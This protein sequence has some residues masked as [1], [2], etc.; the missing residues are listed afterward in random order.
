MISGDTTFAN[1]GADF[2]LVLPDVRWGSSL[3]AQVGMSMIG[4]IE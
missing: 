2:W 3:G 4:G 1:M